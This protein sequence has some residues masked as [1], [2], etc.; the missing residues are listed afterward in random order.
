MTYLYRIIFLWLGVGLFGVGRLSAQ[1]PDQPRISGDFVDLPF[2]QFVQYVELET[3]YYFYYDPAQTDSLLV[4]LRV[5]E[6]KLPAV[7]R[8]LFNNTSFRF[9]IDDQQRVYVTTERQVRTQLPPNFFNQNPA[10]DS[11]AY[12]AAVLDYL[13]NTKQEKLQASAENKLYKIGAETAQIGTGNASIA[14]H[15]RNA[16]SGEP[17]IGA[18]IYIEN[19]RIGVAAD[20]FG[21][22]SLTLPKGRHELKIQSIGMKDT[23]R[24]IILYANGKL[25]IELQDDVIPLKEVVIEGEKDLNVSGLQMGLERLDIKT[26]KQVPTVFGE[27]DL[28][29]VI[30]TLPG[31]K[32]VGESSTGL[33]VRGGATDQNLILFNDATIYNPSHLFGFFSAFNPDVIKTVELY[34]S[35]IPAKYG[36]RLSSVL[37][38]TTRDGN[39]KKFVGSGGIGLITGRLSLEGPIVKD[40]TSFLISGR[41]TYSDWLLRQLRNNDFN[42]S[43]ASFYD[44]NLHVSHEADEKN[45]F[46]LTGYLSKD[47]F[48]LRSD[49]AYGYQNQNAVLKWKHIFSNKLYGVFTGSYSRYAYDVSSKG[50]PVNAYTLNFDVNQTNLKADF[51]YFTGTK[52]TLD[53]GLSSIYYKLFPGNFQPDGSESLINPNVIEPEQAVESAVYIGD[54]F[55]INPKLSINVG[56]RYSLFNYLGPKDV[57]VYPAGAER[58]ESNIRDTISYAPGNMIKTYHGPEYRLSARYVLTD[59]SSVKLS[60]NRMRQYIHALSNTTAVSP[61][62]IWKLSDSHIQPQ[63]GDQYAIGLY[64]NFKSNTIETSVEAYYKTSKNYLDYKSGAVLLLNPAIETDVVSAEGKAYG[65]E[66]LIKKLTGKLNGW[67][68]YTYSRSLLR[69]ASQ[70]SSEIINQGEYY[71]S[72]YDKPHDFTLIGNYKINRRFSFSL[73]F[74]YSTGRPIT[75]PLGK[76]NYAGSQRVYYSERNQYRIPDYYRMDFSMNIEGNHKIKKLA[77]SSWTIAVYNLLG[78]KNPYSVYFVSEEN[79][80]KGYQLSIFGQPIPTVTYNFRF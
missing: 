20:Q 18:V 35:G 11:V 59:N 48:K 17:I 33:N 79:V 70:N 76:Y 28:L 19:P 1:T 27:T 31:V 55:D 78:R 2:G 3:D 46:Y 80:I 15:I 4:N 32:S 73:N 53:F 58:E 62:D 25:D 16:A 63:V 41:T 56:F 26:M 23:K 67:V 9:A 39:K 68:S 72:N 42:N 43:E 61:T 45:S 22:Y 40:K 74:T 52:H 57:F 21:Y 65:V 51:S 6:E 24:Q 71:P 8:Q 37:E 47:R 10:A 34:K 12:D 69:V 29:K 64:K 13:G 49:T 14:G 77:H 66:V 7:L 50:N 30:L 44:V 5:Q 60:Y 36:G 38:V 75:L 54:R